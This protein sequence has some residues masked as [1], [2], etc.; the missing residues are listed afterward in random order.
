MT[1]KPTLLTI[2]FNRENVK[3]NHTQEML[4]I[5]QQQTDLVC[6][7]IDPLNPSQIMVIVGLKLKFPA[8]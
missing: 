7:G 2:I 8:N 3:H 6:L 5:F 4:Q 1:T